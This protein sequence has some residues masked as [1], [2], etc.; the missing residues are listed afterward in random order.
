LGP[1][2]DGDGKPNGYLGD[3]S[4]IIAIASGP[5]HCLALDE[6]GDIWGWGASWAIGCGYSNQWAVSI[7]KKIVKEPQ[8]VQRISSETSSWYPGIQAA[9][10]DAVDGDEIVVYPGTYHE[11][12]D[13]GDKSIV[14]RSTNPDDSRI[15]TSINGESGNPGNALLPVV[16][17][18]S[19]MHIA[20][21]EFQSMGH[22]YWRFD[23]GAGTTA[24][25]CG[26]N[27]NFTATLKEFDEN[28]WVEGKV[29]RD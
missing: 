16:S 2:T 27:N 29:N 15:Q 17:F 25:D 4:K 12:I 1:D 5:W 7:P 21:P 24:I 6:E 18:G 10:D 28:C 26:S 8:R 13:F 22:Y 23:D 19:T 11:N 14:V 20:N 3:H 9:I